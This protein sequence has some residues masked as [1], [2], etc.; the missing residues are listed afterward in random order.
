MCYGYMYVIV[1]RGQRE[2]DLLK[3]Q[4]RQKKEREKREK[5]REKKRRREERKPYLAL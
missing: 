2:S 3:R 4:K 1:V 5:K